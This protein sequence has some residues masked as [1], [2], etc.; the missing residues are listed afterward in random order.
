M[1]KPLIVTISVAAAVALVTV[2]IVGYRIYKI[3]KTRVEVSPVSSIS[4]PMWED[5]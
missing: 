1:K 2:S 5:N 4:T 3:A